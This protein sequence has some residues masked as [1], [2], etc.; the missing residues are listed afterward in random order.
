MVQSVRFLPPESAQFGSDTATFAM[1]TDTTPP[2]AT[3]TLARDVGRNTIIQFVGKILGTILGFATFSIALR[4]LHPDGIGSYTTAMAYLGIGSV[5]ADLGLY[6]ILV[7]DL[8]KPNADPARIVG[9]LLALRWLSAFIILSVGAVLVFFFPFSGAEK[10]AVLIGTGSFIAIAATQLLTAVFQTHRSMTYVAIGELLGRLVLLAGTVLVIQLHGGLNAIMIAVVSGSLINF[11]YI[12]WFS[13]RFIRFS[14]RMDFAYW[15]ETLRDTLPIAISIVLNLIYFRAD[16]IILRVFKGVYDVGLYGAAYR[17]LEILNTFPLIFVGLLL[18]ALA[19]SFARDDRETFIKIFQRGLDLLCIA[20]GLLVVMG[21]FLA[22]PVMVAMGGADFEPAAPIFRF[23]LVAVA[24]LYLGSL[25]GH[26]VTIINRQRQ[27]VWSYLSVAVLGLGLYFSLIPKFSFYGAAVGTI[28]TECITA[29]VGYILIIR[30]LKFRPSAKIFPG[31]LVSISVLAAVLWITTPLIW[32]LRFLI[33][34]ATYLGA[35][36]LTRTLHWS[37]LR[38][39]LG[40]KRTNVN[41]ALENAT[42]IE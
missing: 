3:S 21:W 36:L 42:F 20:I 17:I 12:W 23:L 22:K 26:V 25:S 37:V 32:W 40:S 16:T 28:V 38:E 7:R 2:S 8:N 41:A 31:L 6:L 24:A 9:N 15:R 33:G 1:T 18:P 4:Y 29:L 35:I 5:T 27:M 10:M 13:R 34:S 14:L 19:A 11:V 39:I 30:V